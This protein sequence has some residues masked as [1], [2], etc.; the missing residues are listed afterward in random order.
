MPS[1]PICSSFLRY[2]R[3]TNYKRN[4]SFW[5]KNKPLIGL[6]RSSRLCWVLCRHTGHSSFCVPNIRKGHTVETVGFYLWVFAF[7]F[8]HPTSRAFA[9]NCYCFAWGIF[10]NQH[11]CKYHQEYLF[12]SGFLIC[13]CAA[14]TKIVVF[15]WGPYFDN[16]FCTCSRAWREQLKTLGEAEKSAISQKRT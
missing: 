3:L 10:T 5:R 13:W 2:V 7:M 11:Q 6:W 8:K 9:N 15:I 14:I 16:S 4:V 12:H 1:F